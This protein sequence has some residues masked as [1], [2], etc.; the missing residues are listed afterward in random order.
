MT[1]KDTFKSITAKSALM[2]FAALILLLVTSCQD[3]QQSGS[4]SRDNLRHG[5]IVKSENTAL[6][7]DPFLFS[8]CIRRLAKGD[9]V[10][11]MGKSAKK[12]RIAGTNEYW[13][14]VKLDSGISG[15][16]FGKNL[17]IVNVKDKKQFDDVVATF[18]SEES[19]NVIKYIEGKWWST[20]SYGDF[21]DHALILYP[22]K[23][24]KSYLK[25]KEDSAKEGKFKFDLSKNQIVF[26]GDTTFGKDLKFERRGHSYTLFIPEK[27]NEMSFKKIHNDTE[28][29]D[30]SENTEKETVKKETQNENK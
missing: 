12:T 24:Y 14:H 5:G 3:E 15:W 27:N 7:I 2:S 8:G 22:D 13:Y 28:D 18:R 21:T 25:G 26:L 17:K 23:K 4:A 10:K 20:N 11:I 16:L 19:G 6:R 1:R 29:P 30:N 9:S